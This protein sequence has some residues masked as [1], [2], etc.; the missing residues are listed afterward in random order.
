MKLQRTIHI[1]ISVATVFIYTNLWSNPPTEDTEIKQQLKRIAYG[2]ESGVLTVESA[3][4][5]L[6]NIAEKEPAWLET[7]LF[8]KVLLACYSVSLSG[9][10]WTCYEELSQGKLE[11]PLFCAIEDNF[12]E[13]NTFG[14]QDL[15][16]LLLRDITIPERYD[17]LSKIFHSDY[18]FWIYSIIAWILRQRGDMGDT[19]A[20]DALK[21]AVTTLE[22]SLQQADSDLTIS[23]MKKLLPVINEDILFAETPLFRKALKIIF[24]DI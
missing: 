14:N 15:S 3:T 24:P 5:T 13:Y 17:T 7:P 12:D 23:I 22:K 1:G 18:E 20:N 2:V 19:T 11:E 8:E 6:K 9:N 4:E 16:S 10:Q 21:A